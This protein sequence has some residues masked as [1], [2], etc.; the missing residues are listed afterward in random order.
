MACLNTDL[1]AVMKQLEAG[2]QE[3]HKAYRDAELAVDTKATT[4]RSEADS[5]RK[6]ETSEKMEVD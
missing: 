2:L 3:L 1:S 5:E 4:K 6:E